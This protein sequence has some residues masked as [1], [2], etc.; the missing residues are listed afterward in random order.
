MI[1]SRSAEFLFYD[2]PDAAVE[3]FCNKIV[4][5]NPTHVF[6]TLLWETYE[7]SDYCKIVDEYFYSRSI[8]TTWVTTT[9]AKHNVGWQQL[10]NQV[11][12]IDFCLLRSHQEVVVKRK[13]KINLTWNPDADRYLFLT[14]KPHKINRAG[15]LYKLR[16]QDLLKQCNYSFFMHQGI[17]QQTKNILP[18][19]SDAEFVEFI[20][21]HQRSPD[22]VTPT[23]QTHNLHYGGIPYDCEMYSDSLFRLVSETGMTYTPPWLSEKTYLTILNNQPFVIAGDVNSCQYLKTLGFETFDTIFEIPSYDKILNIPERLDAV[24]EHVKQWLNGNFDQIR[25]AEMIEHNYHQFETVVLNTKDNFKKVTGY[26]IINA[27]NT[28]DDITGF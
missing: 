8:P 25:V 1:I 26:N 7:C 22:N 3:I 15:L 21:Q 17:W 23:M 27:V 12:F 5:K 4:A 14:G 24:V 18:E 11:I 10:Q 13:S 20:T 2:C 16:Q 9:W 19:L 6:L 28:R